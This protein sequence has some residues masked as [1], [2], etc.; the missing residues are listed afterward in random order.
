MATYEF[1]CRA[2]GATFASGC[3]R[4]GRTMRT[5]LEI[6]LALFGALA[7]SGGLLLLAIIAACSLFAGGCWYGVRRFRAPRRI[8]EP[9]PEER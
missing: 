6:I 7:I 5:A 3:A 1:R 9:D 4:P 8:V 2:C